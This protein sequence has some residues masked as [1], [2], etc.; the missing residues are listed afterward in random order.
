MLIVGAGPAG[1][2]T[3]IYGSRIGLRTLIT[4]KGVAGGM[5]AEAPFVE[6][7]PGFPEGIEGADLAKKMVE[8]AR[9]AGV[10]ISEFEEV[11]ELNLEGLEKKVKTSKASYKAPALV[12]ATGCTHKHLGIPGEEEFLGRGVS[13]CAV[14]DG[15]LFKKKKVLVVG[16]GNA[17]FSSAMYLS[18]IAY[19]VKLVHRR[20]RLRVGEVATRALVDKGVKV[21]WNSEV[22]AIRGEGVVKN[23]VL[24]DNETCATREIEV[25]GVFVQVGEAANSQVAKNAGIKVDEQDYI[26]V[27]SRQETNVE[28][29]YACG[30]VTTCQEKQIGTAV[31]Q[32]VVAALDA[33]SYIKHPYHRG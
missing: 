13:Y 4:E 3:G 6:N 30:D 23:V 19:E 31:G 22:K 10:T 32:G 21:L 29:V 33:F 24:Y 15:P 7:Y 20:K 17:A 16:G 8:Q 18:N 1:L 26:E 11:V 5:V 12:I 14:C 25:D 27:D 28:G 9:L 2:T